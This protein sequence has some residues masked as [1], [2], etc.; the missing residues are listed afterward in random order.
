MMDVS[1]VT[2]SRIE[3]LAGLLHPGRTLGRIVPAPKYVD[4]LFGAA[5]MMDSGKPLASV[6]TALMVQPAKTLSATPVAPAKNR[7]SCPKG[8]C[9]IKLNTN[10][11]GTSKSPSDCSALKF[12]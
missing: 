7:L 8:S 2:C 12:V 9:W 5:L 11:C 1:A 6:V 3:P 4:R 10:L